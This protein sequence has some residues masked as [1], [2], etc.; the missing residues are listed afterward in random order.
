MEIPKLSKMG[1]KPVAKVP[2]DKAWETVTMWANK[3]SG[4]YFSEQLLIHGVWR[5]S[6]NYDILKARL[7]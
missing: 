2:E 7:L 5:G 6:L 1:Q 4:Q 3:P